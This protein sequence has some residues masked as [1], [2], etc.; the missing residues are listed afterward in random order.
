M[1]IFTVLSRICCSHD[2]KSGTRKTSNSLC[3]TFCTSSQVLFRA[4]PRNNLEMNFAKNNFFGITKSDN[5]VRFSDHEF[6]L[7]IT[8]PRGCERKS[9]VYSSQIQGISDSFIGIQFILSILSI[10]YRISISKILQSL[11]NKKHLFINIFLLLCSKRNRPYRNICSYKNRRK[12][13]NNH[14]HYQEFYKSKS[15]SFFIHRI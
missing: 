8:R 13:A 12:Y 11:R 2:P 9:A 1:P 5:F 3:I 14:Q 7:H 15:K 10:I 4:I 6:T